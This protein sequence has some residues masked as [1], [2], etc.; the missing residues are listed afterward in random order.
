MNA[1]RRWGRFSLVGMLGAGLQ[2]VALAL[3]HQAD[4][5][6]Y[7]ASVA[8]AFEVTLLHNFLWHRKYTWR[9]RPEGRTVTWRARFMRF[10]LSNGLISLAGNLLVTRWL[11]SSAHEPLLLA[12]ALAIVCCSTANFVLG[13]RWVFAVAD[14]GSR[15]RTGKPC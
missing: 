3:L 7:L 12:N 13:T 5:G 8:V 11:V 14:T 15:L 10:H 2:V 9:D 1:W 4:R 6:H